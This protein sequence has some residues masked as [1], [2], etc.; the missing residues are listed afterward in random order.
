MHAQELLEKTRQLDK[1]CA[2]VRT[3]ERHHIKNKPE[4]SDNSMSS[5]HQNAIKWLDL[6]KMQDQ[7][8][9]KISEEQ[10]GW[11]A[12]CYYAYVK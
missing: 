1:R 10:V 5:S 12:L 9:E 7:L 2:A 6:A 8:K 11:L 3:A 4:S